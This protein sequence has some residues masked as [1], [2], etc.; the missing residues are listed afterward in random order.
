MA[1][2]RKSLR[3]ARRRARPIPKRKPGP[4]VPQIQY[5]RTGTFFRD[6]YY[7][8]VYQEKCENCGRTLSVRGQRDNGSPEYECDIEVQCICGEGVAFTIPVN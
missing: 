1:E 2:I 4:V 3:D 6:M 5:P 7:Q 8:Q